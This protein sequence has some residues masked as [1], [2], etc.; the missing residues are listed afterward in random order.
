MS[1]T[2][3]AITMAAGVASAQ[4]M[5]DFSYRHDPYYDQHMHEHT[6]DWGLHDA[7][8]IRPYEDAYG[9]PVL[10]PAHSYSPYNPGR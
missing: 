10:F 4:H 6:N 5:A 9:R 3:F 1:K 7:Y 8:G 2:F